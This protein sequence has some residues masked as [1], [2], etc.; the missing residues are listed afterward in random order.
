MY[1]LVEGQ[2][3]DGPTCKSEEQLQ[4]LPKSRVKGHCSIHAASKK[5]PQACM[6]LRKCLPSEQNRTH[7]MPLLATGTAAGADNKLSTQRTPGAG[8]LA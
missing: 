5:A 2:E 6:D 3:N 1:K 4:Q 7:D 8:C